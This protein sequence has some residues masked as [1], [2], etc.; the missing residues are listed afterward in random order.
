MKSEASGTSGQQ[1][2]DNVTRDEI[3]FDSCIRNVSVQVG[4]MILKGLFFFHL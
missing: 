3:E 1:Q 4:M 2:L